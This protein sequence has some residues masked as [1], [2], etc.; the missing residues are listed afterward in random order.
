MK[1]KTIVDITA[2]SVWL[3]YRSLQITDVNGDQVEVQLSDELIS[4]LADRFTS[5]IKENEKR[6]IERIKEELT[7]LEN[8]NADS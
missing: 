7:E 1:S 2:N 5:R 4:Y 3:G 8:A 6:R